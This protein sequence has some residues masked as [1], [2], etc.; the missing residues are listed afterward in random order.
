MYDQNPLPV[1]DVVELE[2]EDIVLA[3]GDD[4]ES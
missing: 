1:Y 2:V 4:N 3:S